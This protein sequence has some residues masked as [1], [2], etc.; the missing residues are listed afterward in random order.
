MNKLPYFRPVTRDE[1]R[2]MWAEPRAEDVRRL[3]LEVERYRRVIADIDKLFQSVDL[4]WKDEVGKHLV[5]LHLLK[6]L[7]QSERDRLD[8]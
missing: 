8:S 3:T 5:A 2:R 1:M 4:A 7:M 6:T